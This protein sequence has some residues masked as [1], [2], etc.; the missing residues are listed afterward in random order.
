VK[1]APRHVRRAVPRE[2]AFPLT[3]PPRVESDVVADRL[4]QRHVIGLSHW[5]C[6][7]RAVRRAFV[8]WFGR[9]AA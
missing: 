7:R 3:A 8:R 2:M 9:A 6:L 1:D 5:R 4:I